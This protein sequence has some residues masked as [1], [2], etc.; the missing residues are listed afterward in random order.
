MRPA[1]LS[2]V[3]S[4]FTEIP[5]QNKVQYWTCVRGA[6]KPSKPDQRHGPSVRASSA[7]EV[8]S[9]VSSTLQGQTHFVFMCS[10]FMCPE[11]SP[12]L[13]QSISF[14]SPCVAVC[15]ILFH[16]SLLAL[17]PLVSEWYYNPFWCQC[18]FSICIWVYIFS[19]VC[20]LQQLTL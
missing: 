3:W 2:P 10:V 1:V 11:L 13:L 6:E 17:L 18:C 4:V 14:I 12:F 15:R 5:L 9:V 19:P 8:D 16:F 20:T 7:G